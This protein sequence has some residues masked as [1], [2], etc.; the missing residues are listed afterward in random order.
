MVDNNT[1]KDSVIQK[2]IDQA[3]IIQTLNRFV[4]SIDSRDY[5]AMR[6]CLTDEINFDYSALFGAVMPSSADE[7]VEN[8]R[9]NHAGFR[10]IQHLTANHIVTVD[11]DKATCT[12]NFAAQHFLPNE[13]GGNLWAVGGRYDYQLMKIQKN[14]KIYGC[15]IHV[16]WTDGNLQLFDLAREQSSITITG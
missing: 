2:L 9:K 10:A 12:A 3:D 6:D 8:V 15:K 7:L 13:R 4:L 11:G 14:W 5:A 1:V 16:S